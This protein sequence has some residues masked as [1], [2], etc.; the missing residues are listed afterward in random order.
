MHGGS[1]PF[2]A[3]EN[4]AAFLASYF[5]RDGPQAYVD[6]A[7]MHK[8]RQH[9]HIAYKHLDKK[10]AARMQHHWSAASPAAVWWP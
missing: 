5:D 8:K 4:L 1:G 3:G 9:Q 7:L 2:E 10:G 6:D